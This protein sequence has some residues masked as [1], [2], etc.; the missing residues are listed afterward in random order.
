MATNV[1]KSDRAKISIVVFEAGLP[2]W[3]RAGASGIT[4]STFRN[5]GTLN[6][7][8]AVLAGA[9]DQAQAELGSLE[10]LNAVAK[11]TAGPIAT[12]IYDDGPIS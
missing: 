7:I 3:G 11:A 9:L 5:D 1:S 8:I 4:N 6:R 2:I 12:K 10:G